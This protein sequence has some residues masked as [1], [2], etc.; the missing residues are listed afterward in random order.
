MNCYSI[1]IAYSK[2]PPHSSLTNASRT[3]PGVQ[4]HCNAVSVLQ[5]VCLNFSLNFDHVFRDGVDD[6]DDEIYTN[7]LRSSR[8]LGDVHDS[9]GRPFMTPKSFLYFLTSTQNLHSAARLHLRSVKSTDLRSSFSWSQSES[10]I[11][12]YIPDVR[13]AC[14]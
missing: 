8:I 5:A 9:R 14:L 2:F 11:L 3:M 7:I 12:S 6:D 10:A 4:L 13:S 1:A